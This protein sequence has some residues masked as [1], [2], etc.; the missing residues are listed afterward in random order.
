MPKRMTWFV[1][2][3]ASGV[4]ATVA[5]GRK[6]R[7]TVHQLAPTNLGKRGATAVR[8]AA[9]DISAAVRD[10]R[11]AMAAKEAELK[12]RLQGQSGQPTIDLDNVIDVT[13]RARRRAH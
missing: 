2:G 13:E 6:V 8:N 1:V 10:G 4:G 11:S 3:A 9:G 12:A 7:R 5:A